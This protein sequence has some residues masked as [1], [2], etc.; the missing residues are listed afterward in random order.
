MFLYVRAGGTQLIGGQGSVADAMIQA[1]GGIDAG[2]EAGI[3]Y[4]MPVTS[5]AIVAAAP[6]FIL[7][8]QS[9]VDSI[10]GLEAVLAI[11]GISETPA[12]QN[13]QILVYDDL[14]LVG[15]TPRTGEFL[16]EMVSVLHP[17]LPA[18]TPV[19]AATPEA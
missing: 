8:P 5:E 17:E 19:S 15:M 10:G 7:L 16:Q 12:A 2:T 11:P 3:Q 6:E 14:L 1:A 9:G 4:F 13:D 18:A